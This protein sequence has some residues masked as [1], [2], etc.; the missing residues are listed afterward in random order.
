MQRHLV[1]KTQSKRSA[2]HLFRL[3]P[4]GAVISIIVTPSKIPLIRI[5]AVCNY[6][7]KEFGRCK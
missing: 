3:P 6:V 1:T 4:A 2:A 5:S 7:L